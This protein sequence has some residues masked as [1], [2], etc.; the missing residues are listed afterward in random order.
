[1][2]RDDEFDH[3]SESLKPSLPELLPWMKSFGTSRF[4]LG[5]Y[6]SPRA[7]FLRAFFFLHTSLKVPK[8]NFESVHETFSILITID[9]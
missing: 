2:A 9:D 7:P 4:I 6:R 8:F 3:L 5:S 1:M